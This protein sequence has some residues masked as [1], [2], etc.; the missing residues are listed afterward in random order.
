MT[1]NTYL[2]RRGPVYYARMAVPHELRGYL[3]GRHEFIKSLG[4]R[5][6]AEAK[7][8]LPRV[9]LV[10][11]VELEEARSRRLT[12]EDAKHAA[13]DHYTVMADEEDR[14]RAQAPTPE[15]V[16]AARAALLA[17]IKA[18]EVDTNDPLAVFAASIDFLVLKE[19]RENRAY[20]RQA[21][22]RELRQHFAE[23]RTPLVDGQVQAYAERHGLLV[24]QDAPE[25]RPVAQA[26]AR[27][28]LEALKRA[29]ELDQG[30][31]GYQPRDRLIT[32]TMSTRKPVAPAGDSI[33]DIFD[34]FA[35]EN[36]KK[37]DTDRLRQQRRDLTL[38]LDVV[39]RRAPM[40]AITRAAVRDF[41]QLLLR[42]PVK[43]SESGAFKGMTLQQAVEHNTK[44]GK[45]TLTD[46][47]V[48]RYLG[49]LGAF[50][51]WA[52]AHDYLSENPTT[53]MLLAKGTAN[54]TFSFTS[55]Q[56]N[57][58]FKMPLFT[59]CADP[60]SWTGTRKPGP[61]LIRDHRYWL[62]LIMLFSGARNGE[63]AQLQVVDVRQLHGRWIMHI[64]T[65]GKGAAKRV[66]TEG[67]MRVVPIHS[68]L[69]RLGFLDYHAA[70]AKAGHAALFPRA[71]RNS[72][73]QIAADF[74]TEFGKALAAIGIKEGRGLSLYSF[75]HGFADALRRAGLLDAQF[76][77]LMG[78][79]GA[80]MTGRYGQMPEG[81]LEDRAKLI[82]AVSYPGLSLDHLIPS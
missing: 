66:K 68:E 38:F 3:G 72:R 31:F 57:A 29:D 2:H 61:H 44:V 46:A 27:A 37:V 47:T 54:P 73:G 36:P 33:L 25:Y 35:L 62:P 42:Y 59:G 15:D 21:R 58:V 8:R 82:E 28:E 76:E 55:D 60:D 34:K 10:W 17:R 32:P 19:H 45:P 52:V 80:T 79:T 5:D 23:G 74:S 16:E 30:E 14:A 64:T 56:L 11:Q 81:T 49:S 24:S 40:S 7:R 75:R 43:A 69:I 77:F 18:G 53:D 63:V 48:N 9:I 1:S 39:G 6:H 26:I 70:Q 67:S 71:T 78:H 51:R 12:R 20:F 13:W 65:E 50:C 41:K 22:A 4:T